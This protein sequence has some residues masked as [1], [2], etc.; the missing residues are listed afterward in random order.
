MIHDALFS[1][2]RHP[3]SWLRLTS[4]T[5]CG[6][7]DGIGVVDRVGFPIVHV[8]RT[9][10]NAHTRAFAAPEVSAAVD[11]LTNMCDVFSGWRALYVLLEAYGPA[12][13]TLPRS[14][15]RQPG[16]PA[17]RMTP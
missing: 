12:I 14:Q 17:L 1:R 13:C 5:G 10:V 8:N 3:M 15:S 11:V 6:W 2:S 4:T 9:D 16:S 7:G